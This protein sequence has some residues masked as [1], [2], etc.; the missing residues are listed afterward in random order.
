MSSHVKDKQKGAGKRVKGVEKVIEGRR[1]TE[2]SERL[3]IQ[4]DILSDI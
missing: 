2:E 1:R 3:L 4:E